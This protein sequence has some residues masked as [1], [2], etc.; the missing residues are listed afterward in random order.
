[1]KGR[2]LFWLAALML[3]FFACGGNK[4]ISEPKTVTAS[5]GAENRVFWMLQR[6]RIGT[7]L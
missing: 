6:L 5:L 2:K 3:L 7:L 4:K 1:M